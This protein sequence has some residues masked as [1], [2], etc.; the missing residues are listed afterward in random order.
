MRWFRVLIAEGV[1]KKTQRRGPREKRRG[2]LA[3]E[4]VFIRVDPRR[5]LL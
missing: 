3:A 4:S 1:G 5:N 2:N